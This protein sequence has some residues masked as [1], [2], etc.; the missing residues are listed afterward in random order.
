VA[1]AGFSL[2]LGLGESCVLHGGR[3]SLELLVPLARGLLASESPNRR[4]RCSVPIVVA[5]F[6]YQVLLDRDDGI[7]GPLLAPRIKIAVHRQ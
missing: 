1:T 6:A 5:L 2:S 7:R 4:E 3:H